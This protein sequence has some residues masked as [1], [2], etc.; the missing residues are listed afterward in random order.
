MNAWI[1]NRRVLAAF[2]DPAGAK[3]VLAYLSENR[4]KTKSIKIVSNRKYDFFKEF[5]FE[6]MQFSNHSFSEWINDC[7][8]LM[9]GTSYPTFLELN[10]I[11]EAKKVGVLSISIVDHWTNLSERFELQGIKI[12]PDVIGLVD[13]RAKDLA[14]TAGLPKDRLLVIGNPYYS[15]LE[16]WKPKISSEEFKK[17]LKINEK[18]PYLLYMPEPISRFGLKSKYGFDEIDGLK[19]LCEARKSIGDVDLKIV[20]KGHPNQNHRII[21]DYLKKHKDSGIIYLKEGDVNTLTSHA[22]AVVGF[23]S[24]ALIEASILGKTVIRPLIYLKKDTIDPLLSQSKRNFINAY[25]IKEF[26]KAI[27]EVYGEKNLH[28]IIKL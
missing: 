20:V 28:E 21:E 4:L 19:L 16:K 14:V 5:G 8:V 13:D 11:V 7:D 6:V 15:Y 24:N 22:L 26:T 10:L 27:S 25:T 12:I 1:E 18:S 17:S 9:T 2:S 3:S 23:F